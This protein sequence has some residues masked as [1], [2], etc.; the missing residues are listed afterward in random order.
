MSEC[1]V[2]LVE[3]LLSLA[4]LRVS[5]EEFMVLCRD[6][7]RISSY[8]RQVGEAVRGVNLPPLYHVWEEEGTLKEESVERR[9]DIEDFAPEVLEG[10]WV[11]VPWRGGRG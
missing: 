5:R 3:R 8:L 11:R 2:D 7:D 4:R 10:R 9:V 1:R 6:V